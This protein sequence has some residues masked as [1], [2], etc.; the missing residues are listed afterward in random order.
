MKRAREGERW[1]KSICMH[2]HLLSVISDIC[3]QVRAT[4]WSEVKMTWSNLSGPYRGSFH[5]NQ[6]RH[7]TKRGSRTTLE[8]DGAFFSPSLLLTRP[9]G[10]GKRTTIPRRHHMASLRLIVG[11]RRAKEILPRYKDILNCPLAYSREGEWQSPV[12]R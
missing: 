6:W 4:R 1:W 12:R 5:L 3:K 2:C 7:A 9:M 10:D 11:G 8:L